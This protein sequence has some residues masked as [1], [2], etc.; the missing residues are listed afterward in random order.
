MKPA[1]RQPV[2]RRNA[3]ARRVVGWMVVVLVGVSAMP[4]MAQ[5]ASDTARGSAPAPAL[6][7]TNPIS[8]IQ[9]ASRALP[10]WQETARRIAAVILGLRL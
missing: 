1:S 4:G 10:T 3:L 7:P 9:N 6:D 5:D 8:V 2:P